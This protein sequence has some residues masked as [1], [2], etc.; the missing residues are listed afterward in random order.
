MQGKTGDS[1]RALEEHIHSTV[2]PGLDGGL[3]DDARWNATKGDL[4]ISFV[5]TLMKD[6]VLL[7]AQRELKHWRPL[8]PDAPSIMERLALRSRDVMLGKILRNQGRFSEALPYLK[9]LFRNLSV[10]EYHVSTGWQMDLAS[11]TQVLTTRK[12][13]T[14]PVP[15]TTVF[16]G[17]LIF[18]L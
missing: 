8:N 16:T 13:K 6:G 17:Y 12:S 15:Q 3:A 4:L 10:E 9:E 5:K 14:T 11:R 2:L 18:V 7:R 1:Y